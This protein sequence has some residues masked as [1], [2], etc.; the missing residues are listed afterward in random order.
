MVS[1]VI[2]FAV[3]GDKGAAVTKLHAKAVATTTDAMSD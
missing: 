2:D 3:N 1:D